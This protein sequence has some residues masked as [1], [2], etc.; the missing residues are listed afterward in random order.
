LLKRDRNPCTIENKIYYAGRQLNRI[1][2]KFRSALYKKHKHICEECGYN[3]YNGENVEMHHSIPQKKC[4]SLKIYNII[5]LHEI[6]HKNIKIQEDRK[7]NKP[8]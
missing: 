7:G 6:C 8:A 2:A 5:P 1:Q 4:V 3:L